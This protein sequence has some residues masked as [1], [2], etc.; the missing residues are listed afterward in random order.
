MLC[1]RQ[2][3]E[4]TIS[5]FLYD[6]KDKDFSYHPLVKATAEFTSDTIDLM[7]KDEKFKMFDVDHFRIKLGEG[8]ECFQKA[9][10]ALRSW[11]QYNVDWV[12]LYHPDTSVSVGEVIGIG[13]KTFG[14]WVL[15]ACRIVYV[16]NEMS[17]SLA[18]H[19]FGFA[20][21]TLE[22]HAAKGEERF[23][24]E[25]DR[26]KNEVFFDVVSFSQPN[27]WFTKLGYPAA[28]SVQTYFGKQAMQAMYDWLNQTKQTPQEVKI[29]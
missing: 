27:S 6:Q 20:Q 18:V 26:K 15:N 29:V 2:P 3:T 28:R 24:I 19:R 4:S 21:G 17:E 14:L 16:I 12:E 22:K 13:A 10:H 11:K 7:K 5:D 1:F 8:S 25:W 9:V 23:L